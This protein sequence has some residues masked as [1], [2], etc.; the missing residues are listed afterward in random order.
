MPVKGS[1]RSKTSASTK[2]GTGFTPG[3][4]SYVFGLVVV[5]A[6][7]MMIVAPAQQTTTD[8]GTDPPTLSAPPDGAT[9]QPVRVEKTPGKVAKTTPRTAPPVPEAA[10]A[11]PANAVTLTGCVAHG[12]DGYRLTDTAGE[13]APRSRNW[14]S[15]FFKKSTASIAFVSVSDEHALRSNVGRRVSVTGVLNGREMRPLSVRR[16]NESCK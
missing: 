5:F 4:G 15:G 10:P 3:P 13:N 1:V 9:P 12:D 16:T 8:P 11:I 14:K 6:V 7:G 2:K